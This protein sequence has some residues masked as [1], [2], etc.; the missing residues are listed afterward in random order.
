MSPNCVLCGKHHR[1]I[2]YLWHIPRDTRVYVPL[3]GDIDFDHYV[4]IHWLVNH[5]FIEDDL[6]LL[7]S[8]TGLNTLHGVIIHGH[9]SQ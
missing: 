4:R 3:I 9:D 5:F 1:H 2:N 8:N 7:S 6:Y